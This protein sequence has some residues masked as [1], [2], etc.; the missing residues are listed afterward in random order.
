[1]SV[2]LN[3]D[4][5]VEV[6]TYEKYYEDGILKDQVVYYRIICFN[7]HYE[8]SATIESVGENYRVKVADFP[9]YKCRENN[10]QGFIESEVLEYID[11]S[12]DCLFEVAEFYHRM[13]DN[14]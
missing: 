1:M 5:V 14:Y 11:I 4:V 12:D 13:K 9:R 2:C 3:D 10:Y 6:K 7:D 8:V